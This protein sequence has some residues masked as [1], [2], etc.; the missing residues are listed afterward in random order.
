MVWLQYSKDWLMKQ[1]THR[2][3]TVG[4][5]PTFENYEQYCLFLT[6][7]AFKFLLDEIESIN[8]EYENT[9][10]YMQGVYYLYDEIS[11]PKKSFFQKVL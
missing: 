8:F 2:E 7:K 9:R 4:V 1:I 5:E 3:W 6:S 10:V 11:V